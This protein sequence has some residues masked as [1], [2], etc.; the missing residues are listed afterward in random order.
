MKEMD[1]EICTEIANKL[2]DIIKNDE[3]IQR[4]VKDAKTFDWEVVLRGMRKLI[5]SKNIQDNPHKITNIMLL[6]TAFLHR[7]FDIEFQQKLVEVYY[8][9]IK[10]IA[11]LL[12]QKHQKINIEEYETNR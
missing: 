11:E 9:N 3:Q 1:E 2:F 6:A 10:Y 8:E 7:G 4:V 12:F 5:I